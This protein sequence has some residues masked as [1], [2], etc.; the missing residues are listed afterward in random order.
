[1]EFI[2][3]FA[4]VLISL[5]LGSIFFYGFGRRGPWGSFWSFLIIIFLGV[6]L[7]D[8]FTEPLGPVW[9]GVG[10]IDLMFIG[11]IFALLLAASSHIGS[12]RT[13]RSEETP[14]DDV[15]ASVIAIGVSFWLLI[16]LF[17]I[18]IAIG[19]WML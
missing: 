4:V 9:Y 3:L 19:I 2:E 5:F 1:M 8:V 17:L 14:K 10:W 6:L 18:S 13:Y 16:L 7:F 12:R 15:E 11:L